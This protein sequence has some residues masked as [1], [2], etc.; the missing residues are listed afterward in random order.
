MRRSFADSIGAI[1]LLTRLDELVLC[2]NHI[3]SLPPSLVL[4]CKLKDLNVRFS[5][6]HAHPLD[7]HHYTYGCLSFCLSFVFFRVLHWGLTGRVRSLLPDC[8][9]PPR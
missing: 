2:N 3:T 8:Q 4:L 7:V 5:L 6:C 1:G 9:Q